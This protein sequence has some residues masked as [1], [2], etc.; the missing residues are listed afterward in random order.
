M[1]FQHRIHC[2][3]PSSP[4]P[5]MRPDRIG[6]YVHNSC[7]LPGGFVRTPPK[8]T[9]THCSTSHSKAVIRSSRDS[10]ALLPDREVQSLA[11]WLSVP[12][13]CPFASAQSDEKEAFEP[14][15]FACTTFAIH[16]DRSH[17]VIPGGGH[18]SNTQWYSKSWY[19]TDVVFRYIEM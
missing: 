12:F 9:R 8:A 16:I 10:H 5:Y 4:R 18:T 14:H 15:L 19:W 2:I 13:R 1:A 3:R 11:P 6:R 7:F 17:P